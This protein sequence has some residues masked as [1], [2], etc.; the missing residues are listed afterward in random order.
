MSLCLLISSTNVFLIVNSGLELHKTKKGKY[1]PHSLP[2]PP[3]LSRL[4]PHSLSLSPSL[5]PSLIHKKC[6]SF[7]CPIAL[8]AKTRMIL[9]KKSAN[10][11]FE[12]LYYYIVQRMLLLISFVS[13]DMN[14]LF[15]KTN[16]T[17]DFLNVLCNMHIVHHYS[18]SCQLERERER[19]FC[20]TLLFSK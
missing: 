4:L 9:I 12:E 5:S 3:A 19:E 11:V 7:F 17:C 1:N 18:F 15:P 10:T 8:C 20:P 6:F 14:T 13:Y 16:I 2:L